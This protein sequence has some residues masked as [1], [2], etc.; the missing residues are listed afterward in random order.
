MKTFVD[1]SFFPPHV[2]LQ[3]GNK[4]VFLTLLLSNNAFVQEC[5]RVQI[6]GGVRGSSSFSENNFIENQPLLRGDT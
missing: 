6:N 5:A 1:K 2:F 3:C 4:A